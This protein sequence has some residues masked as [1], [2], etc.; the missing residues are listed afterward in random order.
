MGKGP[1]FWVIHFERNRLGR[2]LGRWHRRKIGN[3]RRRRWAL[4]SRLPVLWLDRIRWALGVV[5]QR[6]LE[7][8]SQRVAGDWV[9]SPGNRA[10]EEFTS[11]FPG[12]C[13]PGFHVTLIRVGG[14]ISSALAHRISRANLRDTSACIEFHSFHH[15][16]WPFGVVATLLSSRRLAGRSLCSVPHL[17]RR[18]GLRRRCRQGGSARVDAW[19]LYRWCARDGVAL[20]ERR[21]NI[22]CLPIVV[23]LRV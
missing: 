1:G 9:R 5:W 21:V 14:V 17:V 13:L 15:L 16:R 12:M 8:S 11:V 10:H 20:L 23:T 22:G 2:R 4:G 3:L 6:L 19:G 7:A 18:R